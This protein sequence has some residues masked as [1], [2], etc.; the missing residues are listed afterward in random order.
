MGELYGRS[1]RERAEVAEA[2]VA[3]VA[4]VHRRWEREGVARC[5]EDGCR[6][7]CDTIAAITPRGTT[8]YRP[9]SCGLN[10]DWPGRPCGLFPGHPGGHFPGDVST[11]P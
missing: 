2:M 11:L 9:T 7:P 6:W 4:S 10:T 8:L 5:S 1:M 3:A